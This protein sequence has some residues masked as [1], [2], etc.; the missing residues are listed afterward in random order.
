MPTPEEAHSM[1]AS[2]PVKRSPP[3]LADKKMPKRAGRNVVAKK[4]LQLA[5]NV[6]KEDDATGTGGEA[7]T[8]KKKPFSFRTSQAER[9][10]KAKKS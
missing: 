3:R 10:R 4:N 7:A 6:R 2:I 9:T 8:K 5:V 1:P